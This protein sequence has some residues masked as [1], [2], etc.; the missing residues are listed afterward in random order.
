[1]FVCA[2]LVFGLLGVIGTSMLAPQ[3]SGRERSAR[4]NGDPATLLLRSDAM[5]LAA[6][7]GS[8]LVTATVRDAFGQPVAGAEVHF[9]STSGN[10]APTT[11]N[12]GI[13][14][15]VS[16]AFGAGAVA[17]QVVITA[18]VESLTRDVVLQVDRLERDET[19]DA[20][21]LDLGAD[22]VKAGKPVSVVA[23]LV[24]ASGQPVGGELITLFGSLGTIAPASKLSDAHGRVTATYTPGGIAG[25]ARISALAGYATASDVLQI[26]PSTT[27]PGEHFIYLPLVSH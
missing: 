26:T 22:T 12:T 6:D 23:T 24:D 19:T 13:D 4:A 8:T 25:Q 9:Q 21:R 16:T 5:V 20:L 14:G 11:A 10:L 17:G 2:L 15:V 27:L 3:A 18:Q 7:S 1:M